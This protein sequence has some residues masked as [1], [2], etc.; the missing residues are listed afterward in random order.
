MTGNWIGD[1]GVKALSEM[2]KE[3]NSLVILYLSGE[4]IKKKMKRERNREQ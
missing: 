3:N 2:L 1:E 4:T